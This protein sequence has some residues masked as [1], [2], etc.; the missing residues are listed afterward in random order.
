MY[1]TVNK[2]G[3]TTAT[4]KVRI[5]EYTDDFSEFEVH[6]C[7]Q[8]AGTILNGSDL[9]AHT[10]IILLQFIDTVQYLVKAL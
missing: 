2:I 9:H 3:G 5:S 10:K 8:A 6:I 1:F 4:E 7:N